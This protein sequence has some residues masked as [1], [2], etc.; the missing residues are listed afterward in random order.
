MAKRE[1]AQPLFFK[2]T[3]RTVQGFA[4][5]WGWQRMPHLHNL[6][7]FEVLYVLTNMLEFIDKDGKEQCFST[8]YLCCPTGHGR[9][10]LLLHLAR[11][12]AATL[13][14]QIEGTIQSSSSSAVEKTG[15]RGGW[16]R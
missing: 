10:M 4:G 9:S 14:S 15:D 8:H 2:V 7:R 6:L 11:L 13:S 5:Y 12:A 1:D 16:S 3:E